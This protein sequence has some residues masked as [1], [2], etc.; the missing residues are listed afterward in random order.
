MSEKKSVGK[1]PGEYP[2]RIIKVAF[3]PGEY[4][5]IID[6]KEGLTTR[7]RAIV[8]IEAVEEKNK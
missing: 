1:P 2:L 7:E 3:A 6:I 5:R 8:L 4:E